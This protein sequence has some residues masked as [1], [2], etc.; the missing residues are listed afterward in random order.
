MGERVDQHHVAQLSANR[1][2]EIIERL[3]EI[4][5]LLKLPEFQ[6]ARTGSITLSLNNC[7]T[8]CLGCPHPTWLRWR[9][10]FNASSKKYIFTGSKISDPL[11]RVRSAGEFQEGAPYVRSLIKEAKEL[12]EEKEKLVKGFSILRRITKKIENPSETDDV[13]DY[14]E[15]D[16]D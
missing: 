3:S 15:T 13:D 6:P 4:A 16:E 14:E 9:A 1:L 5:E 12:L 8:G 7:G 2:D 10:S 11:N